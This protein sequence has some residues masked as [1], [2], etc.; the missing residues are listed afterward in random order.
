MPTGMRSGAA[1]TALLLLS[2]FAYIITF[3]ASTPL[4][5]FSVFP[6][7][8]SLP[9]SQGQGTVGLTVV[10]SSVP[11]AVVLAVKVTVLLPRE[12][13]NSTGG[14]TVTAFFTAQNP[15]TYDFDVHV[16][17]N[18]T[19]PLVFKALLTF[20]VSY[21]NKT[22][23]ETG[24]E[25]FT[26]PYYGLVGVVVTSSTSFVHFGFNEVPISVV[27]NG[28]VEL[29][30]VTLRAGGQT[31]SVQRLGPHSELT[32]KVTVYVPPSNALSIDLPVNLTYRTPYGSEVTL[33]KVLHFIVLENYSTVAVSYYDFLSPNPHYLDVGENYI[34]FNITNYLGITVNSSWLLV[35]ENN[36][37]IRAFFIN[38][39]RPLQNVT[40]FVAINASSP[41][42]FGFE[43]YNNGRVYN[44]TSL[45]IP[46][47]Y[48]PKLALN[49]TVVGGKELLLITNEL[50]VNVTNV[51]VVGPGVNVTYSV[52]EP[53]HTVTVRLNLT[54]TTPVY[55]K[56][57]AMNVTVTEHRL[58]QLE[59]PDL[60]VFYYAFKSPN[61][62]VLLLTIGVI[63]KG[64]VPIYNAYLLLNLNST[65]AQLNP[66]VIHIGALQPDQA[67]Y[68]AVGLYLTSPLPK[69][70][71][72]PAQV[73]YNDGPDLMVK[74][75]TLVVNVYSIYN[76]NNNPIV[77]LL[78]YLSYSIDGIPLIFIAAIIA[79][80]IILLIPRR[81]KRS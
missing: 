64:D 15:I 5:N 20:Y 6:S 47:M 72:I 71:V 45:W 3:T 57:T 26:L 8:V 40:V 66:Y 39:W 50:G 76:Y 43:L 1:A 67:F 32:T 54:N 11:N 16:G 55:V 28:T 63:N 56:Y 12:V 53:G 62:H 13:T 7:W 24:E 18:V 4:V 21:N 75:Y 27:N 38:D 65:A 14:S 70:V 17:D 36:S 80:I 37:V 10:Y 46:I 41:L 34:E 79:L 77:I 25:T 48:S 9:N 69:V 61:P 29:L 52:I 73:V 2:M 30:N 59:S 33:Y 22:V 68:Q 58:I 23:A 74:N 60:I 44:L 51:T 81:R 31:V 42:Y 35:L 78:E 19:N 49:L